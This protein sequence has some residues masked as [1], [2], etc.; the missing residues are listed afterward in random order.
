MAPVIPMAATLV[1]GVALLAL[2]T[3]VDSTAGGWA[4]YGMG[5]FM[6]LAVVLRA[7]TP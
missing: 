6:V 7:S 3:T 4:L 5:A 2:G 1:G